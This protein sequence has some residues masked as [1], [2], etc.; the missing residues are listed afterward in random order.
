MLETSSTLTVDLSKK[1]RE[2]LI[3]RFC[4]P[5]SVT[6]DPSLFDQVESK[7]IIDENQ[8]ENRRHSNQPAKLI[9]AVNSR[10]F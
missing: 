8:M 1:S 10:S 9:V 2:N 4:W 7:R 5:D 6:L 3:Y